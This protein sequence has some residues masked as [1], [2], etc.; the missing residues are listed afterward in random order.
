MRVEGLLRLLGRIERIRLLRVS[1]GY[2][3]RKRGG[4]GRVVQNSPT[5]ACGHVPGAGGIVR[6]EGVV[7][8]VDVWFLART[9]ELDV[10]AWMVHVEPGRS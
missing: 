8:I 4:I 5:G 10:R 7:V 3:L 6:L 1:I 2:T 9:R